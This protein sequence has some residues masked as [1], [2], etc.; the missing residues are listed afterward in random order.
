MSPVEHAKPVDHDDLARVLFELE[1]R[2]FGEAEALWAESLT[3]ETARLDNIPL[4][5][6]GVSKGDVVKVSRDDETPRFLGVAERGGH[7]T[8]RVML[9]DPDDPST[10]ARFREIVVLGCGHERLTPR[11]IAVDV[12]P[13][14]DIFKVYDLL[15]KGLDDGAWTFEEGHCGHPVDAG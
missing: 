4:L 11:F 9:E 14:I 15:E 8:Y 7:S 13:D 5:V 2:T 6:F 12:P 1:D 10:Q 3:P